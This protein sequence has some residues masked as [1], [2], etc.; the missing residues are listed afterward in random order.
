[1]SDPIKTD[2]HNHD[3]FALLCHTINEHHGLSTDYELLSLIAAIV[4]CRTD[5]V[6]GMID[7]ATG[8][9]YTAKHVARAISTTH[10]V[11]YPE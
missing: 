7:R 2:D 9:R 6:A 1:M 11:G 8:L 5:P 10:I 3:T 4:A